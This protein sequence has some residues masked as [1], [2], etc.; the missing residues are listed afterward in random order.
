MPRWPEPDS[1]DAVRREALV[2]RFHAKF[3]AEQLDY[4]HNQIV[5]DYDCMT[6]EQLEALANGVRWVTFEGVAEDDNEGHVDFSDKPPSQGGTNVEDDVVT[7]EWAESFAEF[8]GLA[9]VED[10]TGVACWGDF[11]D[12]AL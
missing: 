12:P 2:D 6:D 3:N 9:R 5:P 4:L 10:S 11:S 1:E 7:F 8:L